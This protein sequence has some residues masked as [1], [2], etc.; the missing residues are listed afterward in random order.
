MKG[1]TVS[2]PVLAGSQPRRG[3]RATRE[4]EWR[5]AQETIARLRCELDLDTLRRIKQD[6]ER[7]YW[8]RLPELDEA[9]E[10]MGDVERRN[11]CAIGLSSRLAAPVVAERVVVD[12]HDG[13]R[14]IAICGAIPRHLAAFYARPDCSEADAEDLFTLLGR[15][16]STGNHHAVRV[17]KELSASELK[18]ALHALDQ[19]VAA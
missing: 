7:H 14:F 19:Q 10:V 2:T 13:N 17:V 1:R 4:R 5:E 9:D 11:S 15:K 3:A 16:L 6:P 18:T 12:L 8:V